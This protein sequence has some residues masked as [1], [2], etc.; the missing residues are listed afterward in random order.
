MP[1][2]TYDSILSLTLSSTAA[3]VTLGSGGTGTI[4]STYTDLVLVMD[5]T[6]VTSGTNPCRIKFNGDTGTNY[7]FNRILSVAGTGYANDQSTVVSTG[8]LACDLD[9]NHFSVVINIFDY[10]NTNVYK[11]T[12]SQMH[13]QGY[14]GQ[15]A[16]RWANTSAINSILITPNSSFA[17]GTT[18]CLYGIKAGN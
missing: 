13:Q 4:P 8:I 9:Q 11:T 10:A 2:T 16:G 14:M 1:T 6:Q 15:Y 5:G 7:S 3:S 17:S 18:F 12:M